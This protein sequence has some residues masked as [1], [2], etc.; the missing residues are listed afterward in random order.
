MKMARIVPLVMTGLLIGSTGVHT[1]TFAATEESTEQEQVQPAF[2][3]ITGTV[4]S[5]EIHDEVSY[6]TLKEEEMTNILA[7]S[8]DTQIFDNTGKKVELKKGDTV[9]AYTDANKPM[10]LIYPPR[11]SP[12]VVIVETEAMGT[13]AVGTFDKNLL[14]ESLS[15]KLNVSE[16][17]ELSSLSGKEITIADLAEQNLLVFYTITTKSIPAQTT[18]LK[19]VL[20]DEKDE[21]AA[22]NAAVEEI[23]S[24]D[25]YE[26]DG[27]KMVPLRLIAEELGYKVEATGKGA[28]LSKGAKS[29]TITRGEKAYG[30][31]K[32]LGHFEVAPALLELGKT[33]VPVD[34][35]QELR[36]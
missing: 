2:I 8:A 33:Y 17:T 22:E 24:K 31:N 16:E 1:T 15:L 12:E 13:A 6:Y 29:F 11:Y 7:V 30:F 4:E 27:I 35:V 25:Y 21:G 9:M 26:V 32:A 28:I 19:V 20:L 34:F 23:I 18:P 36:D 14:D 5:V 10:I 3:K